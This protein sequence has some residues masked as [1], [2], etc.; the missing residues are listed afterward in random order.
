MRYFLEKN[1][2][3]LVGNLI[4][5]FVVAQYTYEHTLR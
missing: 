4:C 2:R 3:H 1:L 5:E